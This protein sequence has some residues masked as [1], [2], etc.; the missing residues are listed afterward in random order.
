MTEQEKTETFRLELNCI[1]NPDIKKFTESM[2]GRLPD[3]FFEVPAS[4]T[5][6][7]HPSYALGDGGLVRHTKA[8]VRIAI[9]LF[10]CHTVTGKFSNIAQDK[11]IAALIL[12]DGCK[13]GIEKQT[14]TV[15]RHPLEIVEFC[16]Q[17]DDVKG[18]IEEKDYS[19]IMNNIATHMGEWTF[20]FKSKRKVLEEPT[21]GTQIFVHMCDYLASRKCLEFNFDAPLSN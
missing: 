20:D 13:S 5:G 16:D 1:Q 14:Y 3:Y 9:E 18:L 7:Y 12:H 19:D 6:K 21:T 8:A 11:I 2:I 10:R 17:Q 4:S 15:A